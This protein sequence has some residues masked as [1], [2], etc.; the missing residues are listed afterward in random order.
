M[1]KKTS[2]FSNLPSDWRLEKPPKGD[3][4]FLGHPSHD[5]RGH[6]KKKSQFSPWVL[7]CMCGKIHPL[8]VKPELSNGLTVMVAAIDPRSSHADLNGLEGRISGPPD[9]D[10][11]Y[12][13]TLVRTGEIVLLPK[14]MLKIQVFTE[15]GTRYNTKTV[16]KASALPP[17]PPT[18]Q[19]ERKPQISLGLFLRNF[20]LLVKDGI[21]LERYEQIGPI[22]TPYPQYGAK[23]NK[24]LFWTNSS[25]STIWLGSDKKDPYKYPIVVKCIYDIICWADADEDDDEEVDHVTE[26]FSEDMFT[27]HPK[28]PSMAKDLSLAI[29][30]N[31]SGGSWADRLESQSSTYVHLRMASEKSRMYVSTCLAALCDVAITNPIAPTDRSF[32]TAVLDPPPLGK[33]KDHQKALL[34]MKEAIATKLNWS[35]YVALR[36]FNK[37]ETD[38]KG[39]VHKVLLSECGVDVDLSEFGN[40]LGERLKVFDLYFNEDLTGDLA[41]VACCPNLN[42]L[43]LGNCPNISGSISSLLACRDSL[44]KVDLHWCKDVCGSI[45]VFEGCTQLREVNLSGD[46]RLIGRIEVFRKSPMLEVLQLTGPIFRGDINYLFKALPK[47]RIASFE[48]CRDI[49]GDISS[50]KHIPLIQELRLTG[51]KR[52]TGDVACFLVPA[53]PPLDPDIE[54]RKSHHF[55][56]GEAS[57]LQYLGSKNDGDGEANVTIAVTGGLAPMSLA[58]L[59][60]LNQNEE[61]DRYA[62]Y[63]NRYH[64]KGTDPRS[65]AHLTEVSLHDCGNVTGDAAVFASLPKLQK[66]TLWKTKVQT[67][68]SQIHTSTI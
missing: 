24:T 10:G 46:D 39:Y 28:G 9:R 5:A 4:R 12:P 26:A 18:T 45:S 31:D 59:M 49:V 29:K 20:R 62:L 60:G 66:L 1:A 50:I 11:C 61:V 41:L 3:W 16:Y 44:Q 2:K 33:P 67:L 68:F 55:D 57:A 51:C 34:G 30:A 19:Q 17:I 32:S 8:P 23:R 6:L 7:H 54:R 25:M 64:G 21:E 13:I 58:A 63:D 65:L 22:P 36:R 40:I 27:K 53:P 38:E 52:L 48:G 37:I 43:N 15:Y 14:S 35:S 42:T 56:S 47:L